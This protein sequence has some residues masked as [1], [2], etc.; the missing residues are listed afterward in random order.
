MVSQTE[1]YCETDRMLGRDWPSMAHT[2]IGNWRL[3][4]I[5]DLIADILE[6]G[7]PGDLLEAGVARGGASIFMRAVL[8]AYGVTD[9]TVWLADSFRGF[10]PRGRSSEKSYASPEFKTMFQWLMQNP[11]EQ[12]RLLAEAGPGYAYDDVKDTFRRYDL[13]DDRVQ[14]LPGFF[15]ETLGKAPIEK[16]ALLRLDADIY[17]STMQALQNLYHKVSPGG[18]VIIDDYYAYAEC[19]QAVHDFLGGANVTILPVKNGEIAVYWMKPLA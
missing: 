11:Q 16:L 12:E 6:R 10:P 14:F 2:M 17:D 1:G 18:Y 13:L 5:A 8:R 15:D 19:R 3:Q 4:N 7:V 9:R